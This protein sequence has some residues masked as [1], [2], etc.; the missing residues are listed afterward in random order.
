MSGEDEEDETYAEETE[1]DETKKDEQAEQPA[2]EPLPDKEMTLEELKEFDGS[3]PSKPIYLAI[4]GRVYDVTVGKDFYEPGGPY[5][6]FAGKDCSRA[7]A[8]VSKIESDIVGNLDGLDE[9][10][11]GV[12]GE[13]EKRYKARYPLVARL[14]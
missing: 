5:H 13:W 6:L 9:R 14:V 3:D 2:E 12:L 11:L 1:E 7:L 8:K 10:A 4:K